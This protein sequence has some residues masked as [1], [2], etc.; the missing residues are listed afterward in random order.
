MDDDPEPLLFGLKFF[1]TQCSPYGKE[2]SKI[3]NFLSGYKDLPVSLSMRSCQWK[4]SVCA[5]VVG[6]GETPLVQSQ[7]K[8][9]IQL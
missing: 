1:F 4:A 3:F 7:R 2:K 8:L 6:L 9:E 5:N